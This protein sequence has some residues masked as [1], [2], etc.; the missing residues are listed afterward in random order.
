ML[1]KFR[2]NPPNNHEKYAKNLLLKISLK[3]IGN[4]HICSKKGAQ[5]HESEVYEKADRKYAVPP[6][7]SFSMSHL[8]RLFIFSKQ[9]K[10]YNKNTSQLLK[11]YFE[12]G[13]YFETSL[14]D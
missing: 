10:V 1:K 4:E 14:N 2:G 13:A 12:W 5:N 8:V 6:H 7:L 11:N 3:I 9:K